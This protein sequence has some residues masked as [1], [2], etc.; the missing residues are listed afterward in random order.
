MDLI[1]YL[2]NALLYRTHDVGELHR[3]VY[4][5]VR[6]WPNAKALMGESGH[7]EQDVS[8]KAR[9]DHSGNFAEF[10]PCFAIRPAYNT[11]LFLL[12][13]LGISRAAVLLSAASYFFIGWL[14]FLWTDAALLSLLIMLTP[15]LLSIGRSTMSDGFA[16]AIALSGLFLIF[17]KERLLPG[18]VLL[19]GAIF[20]RT[21][22]VCLVLPVLAVLWLVRKLEWWQA[23]ALGCMAVLSVLTIN[24][25][26]G[27][28]GLQMLYYRNFVSTPLTPA[29]TTVHFSLAQYLAAFRA[30]ISTMLSSYL[31]LFV[32]L[33]VLGFRK[34]PWLPLIAAVY[35]VLHYVALPNYQERWFAISYLLC[36]MAAFTS[37]RAR[38]STDGTDGLV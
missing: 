7:P 31:V 24:H 25:F 14:L 5:E 12:S 11:M 17:R 37:A 3:R 6:T 30:G 34:Y 9:A 15:P 1:G 36:A 26:A 2:G 22:N 33:G 13:P 32:I 21:D 18:L 16:L 28:Y 27:D 29:E 10:L 35:A 38:T 19:L 4:A 23:A 8:R 20:A